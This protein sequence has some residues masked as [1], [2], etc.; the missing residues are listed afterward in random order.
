MDHESMA[1]MEI[2]GT[3]KHQK[4]KNVDML[5]DSNIGFLM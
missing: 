4:K 2:E 5:F 3:Q 1:L